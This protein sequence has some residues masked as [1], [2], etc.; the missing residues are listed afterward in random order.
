MLFR[1]AD[2]LAAAE[3]GK[4]ALELSSK[5]ADEEIGKARTRAGDIIAQ[6][7]KRASQMIEEAKAN[8]DMAH[9]LHALYGDD[10]YSP[11]DFAR[12]T[13]ADVKREG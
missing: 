5:Q 3:K 8:P 11:A 7:E 13:K 10:V 4:Q 1:S 6:A 2:G 12:D 9:A